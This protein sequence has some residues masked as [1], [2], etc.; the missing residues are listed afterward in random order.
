M[1]TET[2]NSIEGITCNPAQGAMYAFP[3]LQF[4][5]KAIK[6]AE[7]STKAG[8]DSGFLERGSDV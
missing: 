5:Q 4:P 6:A 1:A 2:F 3:Q 8:A 7:V